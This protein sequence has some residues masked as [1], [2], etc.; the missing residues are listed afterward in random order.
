MKVFTYSGIQPAL[1]TFPS[2][3]IVAQMQYRRPFLIFL[4]CTVPYHKKDTLNYISSI[5][6]CIG[7]QSIPFHKNKRISIETLR[8]RR[9]IEDMARKRGSKDVAAE[10]K[11]A[12]VD[13]F[14]AGLTPKQV[15]MYYNMST[16][17]VR[18]I[19]RRYR[20]KGAVNDV[21]ARGRKQ[22]LDERSIRLLLSY[23]RKN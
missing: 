2:R 17:T 18:S 13:I 5:N 22:K 12:I 1:L 21:H 14:N 15:A 4:D 20:K 19:L 11:R 9:T 16:S 3:C 6:K 23:M 7:I 10:R 8:Y